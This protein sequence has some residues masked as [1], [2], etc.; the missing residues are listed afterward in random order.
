MTEEKDKCVACG[1]ETVYNKNTHI[2]CREHYVEG[3]GQ[4]CPDCWR[5]TYET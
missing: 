5:R 2:D 1:K 3:A 4:L